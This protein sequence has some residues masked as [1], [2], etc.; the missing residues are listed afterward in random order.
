MQNTVYGNSASKR[1]D[2]LTAKV[3]STPSC[4]YC[5]MAKRYLLQKGVQVQDVDVSKDSRAATEM[6]QRTGQMGVPV[7]E[8]SG[9]LIVGFDRQRIDALLRSA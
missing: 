9:E 5:V 2:S 8:M 7:V 4:P 3:Y 1:E 6:V